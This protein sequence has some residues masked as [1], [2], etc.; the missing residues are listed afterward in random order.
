M[1]RCFANRGVSLRLGAWAAPTSSRWLLR[2]ASIKSLSHP[3]KWTTRG[4]LWT[5]VQSRLSSTSFCL[6]DQRWACKGASQILFS[7]SAVNHFPLAAEQQLPPFTP[8]H[9]FHADI[10]SWRPHAATEQI[11][12]SSG[13]ISQDD[14]KF[15]HFLQ[16][17]ALG[18]WKESRNFRIILSF[19]ISLQ[20]NHFP[21]YFYDEAL[22]LFDIKTNAGNFPGGW[23]AQC[24]LRVALSVFQCEW[25]LFG[26]ERDFLEHW[27]CYNSALHSLTHRCSSGCS[28]M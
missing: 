21:R 3:L 2:R 22:T 23:E 27:Y 1:L 8:S 6:W 24:M 12:L 11:F 28:E 15:G 17:S 4:V 10:I 5:V 25:N 18:W 9:L 7:G 16:F 13:A 20:L 26:V 19:C 14:A